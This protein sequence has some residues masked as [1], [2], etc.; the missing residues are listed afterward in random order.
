MNNDITKFEFL[1]TLSGNIV[2]QRFFSVMDYNPDAKNSIEMFNHVE[3][4]CDEINNFLKIKTLEYLD[5]NQNIYPF[6]EISNDDG[7]DKNEHFL[8]EIKFDNQVFIQRIFPAYVFPP[9]VRYA[10]DIRPMLRSF[11]DG[12][13]STLSRKK[14]DNKYL[15]YAL[16]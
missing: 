9:K 15:H 3:F 6:N 4:I 1:L 16:N 10:V 8:L 13:S 14:V 12:L 11:L 2:V 7:R 5:S